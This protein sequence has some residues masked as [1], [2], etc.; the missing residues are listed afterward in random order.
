MPTRSGAG[1]GREPGD[2]DRLLRRD[3]PIM[4]ARHAGVRLIRLRRVEGESIPMPGATN[5][6]E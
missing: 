4:D 5:K 3:G 6:R 2:H 1:I